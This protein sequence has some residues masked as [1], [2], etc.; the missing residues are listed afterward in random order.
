MTAVIGLPGKLKNLSLAMLR[1]ALADWAQMANLTI[2]V[3]DAKVQS[4]SKRAQ[5]GTTIQGPSIVVQT[6]FEGRCEAPC[7]FVFPIALAATAVGRFVM[8]PDGEIAAKATRGLDAT[9]LE[10]FQ[11]MAN[12]L[13]GSSN[14]VISQLL[15]GLRLSQSVDALRVHAAMPDVTARIDDFPE[16]DLACVAVAVEAEGRTFTLHQLL[17]LAQARSMLA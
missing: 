14:G 6:R 5:I 3:V 12:L 16:G 9:D 7:F 13:C 2:T 1:Q 11:E 17:P 10:A 15:P 4:L 8:L